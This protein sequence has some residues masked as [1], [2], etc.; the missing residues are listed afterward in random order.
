M[1]RSSIS[2][3]QLPTKHFKSFEHTVVRL[4]LAN[5]EIM[6]LIFNIQTTI[7]SKEVLFK[8]TS[9]FAPITL[10]FGGALRFT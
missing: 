5:K 1:V 10:F 6:I 2:A 4:F 3:K 9:L 7:C 8:I